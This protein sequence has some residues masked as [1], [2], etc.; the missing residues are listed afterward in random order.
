MASFLDLVDLFVQLF[1]VLKRHL[2]LRIFSS[3]A[4]EIGPDTVPMEH[5]TARVYVERRQ[6][7]LF[8]SLVECRHEAYIAGLVLGDLE[9]FVPL[10]ASLLAQTARVMRALVN[11]V[12]HF[13]QRFMEVVKGVT[14]V[15]LDILGLLCRVREQ[16]ENLFYRRGFGAFDDQHGLA[17]LFL[18]DE[19]IGWVGLTFE[20]NE[21]LCDHHPQLLLSL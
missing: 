16:L 15:L 21:T 5:M 14:E 20:F 19:L 9:Q 7:C 13:V 1:D 4:L 8:R 10:L 3:I 18:P 12:S 6:F 2:N 17:D 11:L